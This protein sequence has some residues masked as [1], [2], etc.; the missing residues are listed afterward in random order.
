[1]VNRAFILQQ[2]L[3]LLVP[4]EKH[5]ILDRQ[6][7]DYHL[8]EIAMNMTHWQDVAPYLGLTDAEEVAIEM[9]HRW[10]ERR[11]L[12]PRSFIISNYLGGASVVRAVGHESAVTRIST[13]HVSRLSPHA[14]KRQKSRRGLG[15]RLIL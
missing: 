14:N 13:S 7:E 12:V 4:R 2:L 8:A 3:R 10:E 9:N 11:R 15:I 1:M 5:H 6:V